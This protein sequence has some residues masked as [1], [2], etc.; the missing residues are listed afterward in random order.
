MNPESLKIEVAEFDYSQTQV[1]Y[2]GGG[3]KVTSFRSCTP[4]AGPW[5]TASTSP[6]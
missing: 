3:V 6:A 2:E 5:A 1:V 4:A